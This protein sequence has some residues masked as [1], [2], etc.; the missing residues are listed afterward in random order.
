ME[1]NVRYIL[2]GYCMCT[3]APKSHAALPACCLPAPPLSQ[4][5]C[6]SACCHSVHPRPS[7]L[8][9]K[10]QGLSQDHWHLAMCAP[11][12]AETQILPPRPP[13][14][15]GETHLSGAP[16]TLSGSAV[17]GY[18]TPRPTAL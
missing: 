14:S 15:G 17:K 16:V 5:S 9:T 11:T 18:C 3:V 1:H 12:T 4:L 10:Q 2:R 13:A 7:N 6:R 8:A